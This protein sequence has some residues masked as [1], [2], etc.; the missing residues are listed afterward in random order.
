M[1]INKR[2]YRY[3]QF[4]RATQLLGEFS[5]AEGYGRLFRYL[6]LHKKIELLPERQKQIIELRFG[7]D[8]KG[9]K[10][11]EE[12][13]KIFGV[14]RERVRQLENRGLKKLEKLIKVN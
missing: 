9:A 10:S 2:P 7:L 4:L 3:Q 11:L 1:S 13:G 14:T 5:K 12:V 8:G 6:K